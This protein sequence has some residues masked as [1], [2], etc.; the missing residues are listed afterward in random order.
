[1][2]IV[3]ESGDKLTHKSGCACNSCSGRPLMG[4]QGP[5]AYDSSKMAGIADWYSKYR[6]EDENFLKDRKK[7]VARAVNTYV[8]DSVTQG[9]VEEKVN[10]TLGTNWRITPKP[11]HESLGWDPEETAIACEQWRKKFDRLLTGHMNYLDKQRKIS[12]MEMLRQDTRTAIIHGESIIKI[13]R[14][15]DGLFGFNVQA[16]HPGRVD[17]PDEYRDD[18]NVKHGIR[19]SEDGVQLGMYIFKYHTGSCRP[20]YA[21]DNPYKYV[22]MFDDLGRV[23]LIHNMIQWTPD[24][25]RGLSQIQA[26][27]VDIKKKTAMKDAGLDDMI[28][29][30]QVALVIR[31]NKAD[32]AEEL[33]ILEDEAEEMIRDIDQYMD[34]S[35][36]H[37]NGQGTKLNNKQLFRLYD[38]EQLDGFAPANSAGP[39]EP[40]NQMIDAGNARPLSMSK[41]FYT[42]DWSGA[43]YSGARSGFLSVKRGVEVQRE[44]VPERT[45]LCWWDV[46][47]EGGFLSGELT[48][49]GISDPA[50]A[51]IFYLQNADL[52][53]DAE[54]S[55]S[56][57]DEIDPAKTMAGYEKKLKAGIIS[58]VQVA[59]E[60]S[61]RDF[62]HDVLPEKWAVVKAVNKLLE[63]DGYPRIHDPVVFMFPEMKGANDAQAEMQ[64][65]VT[66]AVALAIDESRD[67]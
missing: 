9:A 51:Y 47:L 8:N 25:T 22:E 58:H 40:F 6:P 50:Q 48:M 24:L 52:I 60:V 45:T 49:P 3:S 43:N 5:K 31:S 33:G 67:Q 44:R 55:S 12:G 38:G 56:A 28:A 39:F 62:L 2:S 17:T 7:I 11:D 35:W 61:N 14:V 13:N 64:E 54:C 15:D 41:E 59:K 46:F 21:H 36:E 26:N 10:L 32:I 53:N 30:A 27:L 1:M 34:D 63:N 57:W 37:H 4:H 18:K 19:C 42:Q 23:Q 20:L 65:A 29:K 66:S 16:I